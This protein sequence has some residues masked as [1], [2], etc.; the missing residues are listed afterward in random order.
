[1]RMSDVVGIIISKAKFQSVAR[2]MG[3]DG[4][5]LSASLKWQVGD[6]QSLD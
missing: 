1:M 3:Q 4:F 6:S 5:A 2:A